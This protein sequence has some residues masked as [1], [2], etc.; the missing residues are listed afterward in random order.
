MNG[1]EEAQKAQNTKRW[2]LF[3]DE[4]VIDDASQDFGGAM[5]ELPPGLHPMEFDVPLY[6]I[7]ITALRSNRVALERQHLPGLIH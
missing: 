4:I 7:T 6:P 2:S 5:L 1:R 3:L